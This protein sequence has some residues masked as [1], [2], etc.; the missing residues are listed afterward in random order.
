MWLLSMWLLSM[1]LL[2]MWLCHSPSPCWNQTR[3]LNT[4][5]LCKIR[6][7]YR[8]HNSRLNP[9]CM[10]SC[11]SRHH[12]SHPQ[13]SWGSHI[14]L[15]IRCQPSSGLN[16][17]MKNKIH[18]Y[19]VRRSSLRHPNCIKAH[20]CHRRRMHLLAIQTRHNALLWPRPDLC[21]GTPN[22]NYRYWLIHN[23]RLH[24]NHSRS[25]Y[26]HH[27]KYHRPPN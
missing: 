12:S 19:S 5:T 4:R 15:C 7:H 26:Y 14:L 16:T 6:T 13:S 9:S 20:Y 22:R 3:D 21:T 17:S 8:C 18:N 27:H 23:N 24:P 2:S 25:C 1:W 10:H 11:C